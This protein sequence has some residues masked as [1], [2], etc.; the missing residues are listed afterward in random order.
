[1]EASTVS[2]HISTVQIDF[3]AM[4]EMGSWQMIF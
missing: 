4:N 2:Y 1:M 3:I